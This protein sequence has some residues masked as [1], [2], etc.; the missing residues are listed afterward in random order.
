MLGVKEFDCT[1]IQEH[2]NGFFKLDPM[3]SGILGGFSVVPT[4]SQIVHNYNIT[5]I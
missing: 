5:L 3:L 4:E 1:A 2:R